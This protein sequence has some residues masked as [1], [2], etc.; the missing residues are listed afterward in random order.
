MKIC[1]KC[2]SEDVN[3]Y[4]KCN[5]CKFTPDNE[6]KVLMFAPQLMKESQGFKESFFEDLY[7]LEANNFW[8]R[9]RNKLIIYFLK[10]YFP[11]TSNFLEIGCGTGYV[12]SG[13]ENAFPNINLSGSEIFVKGLT[14]ASTR[15]Q[16]AKLFQM[17]AYEIPFKN[18]FNVIGMFDVL[19]HLEHDLTALR[20]VYSALK[21]GGGILLTVPHHKFLWSRMD[22]DGHHFRRYE[23]NELI[24]KVSSVGFT[25]ERVTSFVFFLLPLVLMSRLRWKNT[26]E[27]FNLM[28]EFD[29][30]KAANSVFQVIMSLERMLIKAGVNFSYG[31]SLLLVAIKKK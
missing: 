8:F 14:Y 17:D 12:L 13:I 18:E 7:N 2:K 25:I 9:A 15:V 27:K 22:L 4:W 24:E 21:P 30:S 23:T 6:H 10:K 11:D 3:E 28:S 1:I 31:S 19:E 5:N 26:M 16:K 20:Q 29:I